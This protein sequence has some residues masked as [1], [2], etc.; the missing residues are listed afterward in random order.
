[1][2][3]YEFSTRPM[4]EAGWRTMSAAPKRCAYCGRWRDDG[5][6]LRCPGPT[7]SALRAEVRELKH[8]VARLFGVEPHAALS[9]EA[10][11]TGTSAYVRGYRAGLALRRDDVAEARAGRDRLADKVR[12]LKRR[13]RAALAALDCEDRSLGIHEA[14]L[15]L[16]LRKPLKGR[17]GYWTNVTPRTAEDLRAGITW[18]DGMG[19][20]N[21]PSQAR[22]RRRAAMKM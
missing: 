13:L 5:H 6:A 11:M 12:E 7:I 10:L 1:M 4:H 17:K 22:F 20:S 14:R 18:L 2:S 15:A 3:A 19:G 9:Q 16:N 21:E 8:R